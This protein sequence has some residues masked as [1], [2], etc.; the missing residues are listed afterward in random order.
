[1]LEA[2]ISSASESC[3][4]QAVIPGLD[5]LFWVWGVGVEDFGAVP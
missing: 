4:S 5:A 1:M 3:N 2:L